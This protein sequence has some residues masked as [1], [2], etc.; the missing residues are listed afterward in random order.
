[1]SN[2]LTEEL[3]EVSVESGMLLVIHTNVEELGEL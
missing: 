3:A 1:M 2:V